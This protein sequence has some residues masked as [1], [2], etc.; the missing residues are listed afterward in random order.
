MQPTESTSPPEPE[1]VA[2]PRDALRGSGAVVADG[3]AGIVSALVQAPA[4]LL[5]EQ[6]R[7]G[8]A[9]V[10]RL[11]T[12]TLAS[13]LVV[14][15]VV[16]SFSGGM[17]MLVVPLKLGV[18]L[19]VC[20]ALCLP[21]L[22]VFSSVAGAEQSLRE[23]VLALSMGV[24]LIGVL[25]VAL[26]PVTWLF[27]QSVTSSAAMG[28]IHLLSL[29]AASLVGLRLLERVMRALNGRRIAGM[30]AWGCMFVIVMLQM[31]TTVR[32][33]VGPYEGAVFGERTFFVAHWLETLTPRTPR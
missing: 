25:L 13:M 32:P 23:T 30:R 5:A 24:A 19:L 11:V 31:T 3:L 28:A 22:Y 17:Q 20:A 21:S 7:P 27:S 12:V 33:L 29:L 26:A 18:G 14:G 6:N 1:P 2:A 8:R 15:L 16:G 4:N 10:R 9:T